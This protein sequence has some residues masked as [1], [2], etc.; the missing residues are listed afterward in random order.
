MRRMMGRTHFKIGMLTYAI[1]VT[2]PV[3]MNQNMMRHRSVSLIGIL[4]AGIA[5]L[6]VDADCGDSK[7]NRANP[8]TGTA[9]KTAEF[10]E[11]VMKKIIRIVFTFGG[12][13]ILLYYSPRILSLMKNIQVLDIGKRATSIVYGT[14]AL[15]IILG[16]LGYKGEKLLRKMPVVGHAYTAILKALHKFTSSIKRVLLLLIYVGTGSWM[17]L[18]NYNNLQDPMLYIIGVLFICT[19]VFPHRTFLHSPEGLILFSIAVVYVVKRLGLEHLSFPIII[20]Y[21][22][23]LYLGDIFTAEGVPLS[24]IPLIFEKVGLHRIL[25][26]FRW[27]NKLFQLLD[28]RISITLMSTGTKWGNIF[29]SI[30]VIAL[31]IAVVAIYTSIN[32]KVQLF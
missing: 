17:M 20:G 24:S 30:C 32:I 28:K 16:I 27:Y 5:A 23:H 14:A 13:G 29:E 1:A 22:S 15:F 18:F 26:K 6:V 21:A 7:I 25:K 4:A 12:G 3:Y 31:A 2:A 9:I 8:I 19:A 11:R 10:F